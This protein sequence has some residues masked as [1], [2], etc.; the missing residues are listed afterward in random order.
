MYTL[1]KTTAI[2]AAAIQGAI[3]HNEKN[4]ERYDRL[5]RY[6]DGDHDI[7]ERNKDDGLSNNKLVTNLAEYITDMSAGYLLGN[8]VKY[9]ASE[10]VDISAIEKEYKLQSITDLDYDIAENSSIYGIDYEYVYMNEDSLPRS[11]ELDVRNTIMVYDNTVEHSK[12]FAVNYRP[13]YSGN[14]NK[15]DSYDVMVLTRT[16][17]IEGVLKKGSWTSTERPHAFSTIPLIEYRNNKRM[18]GDF[19]SVIHLID[20]YNITQSDRV[21][22]REQ[23]VDAILVFKGVTLDSEQKQQVIDNRVI[24]GVPTDAAVEY[25]TKMVNEA[26]ID[27]LRKNIENDIH[28]I[29][30]TPNMT[31]ENFV[32]NSSGVAIR[33]KLLPFEQKTKK[34]ERYIERGLMQRMRLYMNA[35]TATS[36]A[37][38]TSIDDVDA[39]F[40]R[41]LPSN[42]YETS[43]MINNLIGVVDKEL[44]VGQLSFVED[45]KE[46]V[47]Q[48]AKESVDTGSYGTTDITKLEEDAE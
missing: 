39:V 45:A 4:R 5:Q 18:T 47:E 29:S 48:A 30:K 36:K 19:E 24:A 25:V 13:V 10:G 44:L 42:D 33:Y 12:L 28:K 27:V 8:P 41:N 9:Q 7:L 2:N 46:T 26:D 40:R 32:G 23:L 11:A 43:Q 22:E 31:D 37:K 20:A 35:L 21:N 14:G 1:P 3:D 17:I 38:M 16:H 6:Y 34:K 15:P